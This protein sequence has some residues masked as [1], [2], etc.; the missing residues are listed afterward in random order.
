MNFSFFLSVL[1]FFILTFCQVVIISVEPFSGSNTTNVVFAVD[2][3]AKGS[4]ISLYFLSLIRAS[5]E[6]LAARQVS[7]HLTNALFGE[8]NSFEVLKFPGGITVI[9]QQTAFLLQNVQIPF[10]FTL[11][12]S[13]RQIQDY[14]NELTSQLKLGLHLMPYEVLAVFSFVFTVSSFSLFS[15]FSQCF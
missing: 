7:L 4:K 15:M 14:F 6:S 2:P 8:T 12:F 9:P 11:N 10:N 13:I 5:F 3:D 1:T